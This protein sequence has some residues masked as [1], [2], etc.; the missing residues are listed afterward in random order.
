MGPFIKTKNTTTKMMINVIISIIPIIL[1]SFYKNGYIPYKEGYTD[2]F[3]MFYPLIFILISI[4]STFTFENLYLLLFNKNKNSL[5]K[6]IGN[7]YAFMPGLFIALVLPINTPILILIFG[8]F[9][10][11]ILGKVVFGGFGQ[12]IFNPA[13]LGC[14]FIVSF[15]SINIANNGGYFNAYELDTISGATPLSNLSTIDSIGTYEQLVEPYGTMWDFL[16]GT[17]PGSVG[18]TSALLC[19]I[20]FLYLTFTKT[21]KWRIPLLYIGTVFIMTSVIGLLNDTNIWYSL[22]QILSGGLMFGAIFMATDPVTSPVTRKGQLIYG[23]L[24]GIL[25]VSFRYLT[26]YPEGVLTSILT[27][28]L[29]VVIIDKIGYKINFSSYKLIYPLIILIIFGSFITL[30]I[31][32]KF[33]NINNEVDKDFKILDVEVNTDKVT[34]KVSQY[35]YSSD[36]NLSI[37]IKNGEVLEASIISSEDSFLDMVKESDYITKLINEQKSLSEIDTISGATFSSRA[38]KKAFINTLKDYE[39]EG[40]KKFTKSTVVEKKDFVINNKTINQNIT[41]YNVSHKSFGGVMNME[42][43]IDNGIVTNINIIS[44]E[45]TCVSKDKSNEHY[46]CPEYMLEGYTNKVIENNNIDTVSGATYSS[47][48]IKNSVTNVLKDYRGE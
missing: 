38:V 37:T 23:I 30:N 33:S 34:Y 10:A 8:C 32:N 4:V 39:N 13:L 25:T 14:L 9:V 48:A 28:N 11:S 29:L 16:I 20:A 31:S 46:V 36:M 3:G 47:A 41:T 40:Y 26:P 17:I 1:F 18:E 2:I 43:I 7:S 15:F 5:R 44:Y 19:I 12:N 6:I 22:F 45:D 21:I 27:M 24:L 35:G 42:I